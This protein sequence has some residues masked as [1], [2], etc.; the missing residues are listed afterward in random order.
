MLLH[1]APNQFAVIL[2]ITPPLALTPT[3]C[4]TQR[5]KG[6]SC[7]IL[8]RVLHPYRLRSLNLIV[9]ASRPLRE[10]GIARE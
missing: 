5:T 8:G 7:G 4:T 6:H 2:R 3:G 9:K 10:L 1:P